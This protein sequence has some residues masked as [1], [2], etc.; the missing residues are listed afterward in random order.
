VSDEARAREQ[1]DKISQAIRDL[2]GL[3][4]DFRMARKL[5]E[6]RNMLADMYPLP[7]APAP[8]ADCFCNTGEDAETAAERQKIANMLGLPLNQIHKLE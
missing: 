4:V 6:I 5:S 7:V 2:D 1:L 8:D 3:P